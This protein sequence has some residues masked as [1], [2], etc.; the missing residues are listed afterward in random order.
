MLGKNTILKAIHNIVLVPV[1]Q[2]EV[3]MLGKNTILKA[4][5]NMEVEM[6]KYVMVWMLGKN[7]ILKA[8]HNKPQNIYPN[9]QRCECYI[10]QWYITGICI[11]DIPG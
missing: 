3:W 4:I 7:T 2:I 11:L 8:I 5:H 10:F 6:N 1:V 9:T